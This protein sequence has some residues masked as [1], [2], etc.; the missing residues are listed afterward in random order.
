MSEE[1][2]DSKGEWSLLHSGTVDLTSLDRNVWCWRK[3]TSVS[4]ELFTKK[5]MY[6][7]NIRPIAVI[8]ALK[9]G[10]NEKKM[11]DFYFS[12]G[13]SFF[14]DLPQPRGPKNKLSKV[15]HRKFTG[16]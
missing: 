4:T 6:F 7:E 3:D 1:R 9:K 14:Y 16:F 8:T 10:Y 15:V 2:P 13:Q 12:E 5:V 11:N